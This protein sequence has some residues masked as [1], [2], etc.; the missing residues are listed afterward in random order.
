MEVFMN[1][2]FLQDEFL[3]EYATFE[4]EMLRFGKNIV[5]NRAVF[6]F[7]TK[8]LSF[9]EQLTTQITFSLKKHTKKNFVKY[10]NFIFKVKGCRYEGE[11][12]TVKQIIKSPIKNYVL[13]VTYSEYRGEFLKLHKDGY[14]YGC[15][16]MDNKVGLC[17]SVDIWF[18]WKSN[19]PNYA[20][21]EPDDEL[22][23]TSNDITFEICKEIPKEYIERFYV[24]NIEEYDCNRWEQV[25]NDESNYPKKRRKKNDF[26][27]EISSNCGFPDVVFSIFMNQKVTKSLCD[28]VVSEFSSFQLEWDANHIYGIHNIELK[29]E[30]I[31]DYL[32]EVVVDF[33]SSDYKIIMHLIKWLQNS[34]LNIKNILI[35]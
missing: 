2:H 30:Q 11:P 14:A 20:Y 7:K 23:L 15:I 27:F 26:P 22:E 13:N 25:I 24:K 6:P 33:G 8:Y 32:V 31:D 35:Q 29:N 4:E 19:V 17:D 21:I 3:P 18:R 5:I 12:F 34:N 1:N 28:E 10:F 9:F 16:S